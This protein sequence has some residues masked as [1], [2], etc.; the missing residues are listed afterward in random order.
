MKSYIYLFIAIC[1]ETAGT[2]LL[3]MTK[4][5]TKWK[6]TLIFFTLFIAALYSL[7]KAIRNIPIGIAYAIWSGIGII[8]I[9]LSGYFLYKQKLDIP[10][11]IGIIFIIIGVLIINLFSKTAGH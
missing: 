3:P 2:S 4:E 9:S 11:I 8:L 1:L 7:T 5:F 6:P 10:A